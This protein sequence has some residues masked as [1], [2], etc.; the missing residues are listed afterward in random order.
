[1]KNHDNQKT[2]YVRPVLRRKRGR[3]DILKN[4]EA[5]NNQF[6]LTHCVRSLTECYR[7]IS[8]PIVE[9]ST[10]GTLKKTP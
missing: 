1:M 2:A 9:R 7:A 10:Y 4:E 6:K 3:E 8:D 5:S